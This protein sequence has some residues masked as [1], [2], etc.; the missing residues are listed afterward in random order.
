LAEY[1]RRSSVTVIL[2]SHYMADVVALCPRV[3][4]MHHGRLLYDGELNELARQLA[5]FKLIRVTLN[6][7]WAEREPELPAGADII[8]RD[9]ARGSLTLRVGRAQ[10]PLLTT[11]LLNTLPVADLA[12][13]DP[14]IEAV[15][16]RIYQEGQV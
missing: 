9:V 12:V 15:I 16:D 1:N 7:G 2:T 11:L 5:P 3:I 6:N 4:L 8:E 14:P 10:A 13:E